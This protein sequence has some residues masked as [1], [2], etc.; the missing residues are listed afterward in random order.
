MLVQNVLAPYSVKILLNDLKDGTFFL[1]A[2]DA[3]N[4]GIIK[5]Y[6]V[7]VKYLSKETCMKEGLLCF[8]KILMKQSMLFL[9][10]YTY[11][12]VNT[13]Y[14]LVISHVLVQT[15]RQLSTGKVIHV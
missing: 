5:C 2:A 1:D 15:V 11:F 10:K 3:S 9:I 6:P 14:K 8:M 13:I 12:S 7:R 4:K